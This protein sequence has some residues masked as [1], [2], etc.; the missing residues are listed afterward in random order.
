MGEIEN[1]YQALRAKRLLESSREFRARGKS[2]ARCERCHL[3]A[4]ACLCPWRR[5]IDSGCDFVVLMHRNE[6]FKP[7]NSGRLIADLLPRNTHL[8]IWDRT[9]PDPQLLALL[10]DPEREC[11]IVFPSAEIDARP[12]ASA[13][14]SSDKTPTFILLDGTWK[15]SGR[16]FHLSRWLD[17]LP[18]FSLPETL[19]RG[20]AVR[21][22]HQEH[23][24]STLEAAGLCL[25][26]VGE[27]AQ[28]ELMFDY[29]S[30]FN[31][32][33]LATRGCYTPEIG[34]LHARLK[35]QPAE[36]STADAEFISEA[37]NADATSD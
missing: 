35:A 18:C 28:S 2:V 34:E 23:F 11:V 1:S 13:T 26:M 32:H 4:F 12:V 22:S 31:L 6:I 10:N 15:Q 29:F 33:Y 21:K 16:M 8:F 25:Q 5:E 19:L 30:L 7:T 36:T 24:V 14:I 9:Q 37:S 20:Y 17:A 27:Q 3:G